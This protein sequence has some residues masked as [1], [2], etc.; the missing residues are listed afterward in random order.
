MG[1]EEAPEWVLHT[2]QTLGFIKRPKL[3]PAL[4]QKP[5]FRFLHD[6]VTEVTKETGFAAGLYTEEHEINSAK[7]KDKDSKIAYLTKIIKCVEFASGQQMNI[8]VGKV[9]AGLEAENTN[10]FLALLG[11][12]A[13]SGADSATA[14]SKVLA[15]SDGPPAQPTAEPSGYDAGAPPPMPPPSLPPSMPASLQPEP[16]PAAPPPRPESDASSF[17]SAPMKKSLE[18]DAAAAGGGADGDSAGKRVRPK[19]ARRPPPRVTSNEVKVEKG[20]PR[21][22]EPAPVA[23]VIMEGAGDEED[24][25]IEMVDNQGEAVNTSSMAGAGGPAEGPQGRLG[26]NLLDAKNEMEAMGAERERVGTK[27]PEEEASTGGIILGKKGRDK[28]GAPG[29]KLP[30]KGEVTALRQSIQTLCQS[31]NPLGRCLEYVQEDLEAMGKEL[32][33]WRASRHRRSGELADE[34]ATTTS[35]LIG[36]KG[37]L[38]KIEEIIKEKHVQIR[39]SKASIIRNDGKIE[40]LLSQVVRA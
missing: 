3:T 4:L 36:L 39:F 27:E 34:E 10:G 1:D 21:A 8:R 20:A 24:G 14:V 40:Q 25:G 5:P 28:A 9:V 30:S 2:Q 12:L 7:I 38:E 11:E 23:G 37:E 15:E 26:K 6:V 19:S 31:S 33:S 18:D 16:A 22:G 13:A 32:E 17:Q 35:A 29:G